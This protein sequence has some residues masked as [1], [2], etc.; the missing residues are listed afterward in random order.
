MNVRLGTRSSKL[1]L[2][3]TAFVADRLRAL[4]PGLDC[5]IVHISTHGDEDRDRPLP[6]IG[7]KGLFTEK[8]EEALREN[9][10]D[11]AVHS[12][13]DLPIDDSPGLAI[14]AVLG[15][16]EARDVVIS[17]DGRGLSALPAG[18]VVGTSSTRREAQL[19]ALRRDLNVKPIRGNVETRIAKVDR[20]E[21]E[22]TVIAGAGVMRL[23]L[24]DRVS[25]WIGIDRC[26]PAPGQGA[27]AVQCRADDQRIFGLLALIDDGLLHRVTDAERQFL[28]RLGG[29]CAAPVAAIATVKD[30]RHD[31]IVLHGRVISLDGQQV[32]EVRGEGDEPFALARRLADEALSAGAQRILAD[33]RTSAPMT[34]PLKGKRVLVTRPREQASDLLSLL[35]SRGAVPVSLPLIRIEPAGEPSR[36]EAALEALSSYDWVVFT[37][38][39]GVEHFFNHLSC[40]SLAQRTAAVGPAT[41]RALLARKITPAFIP[42][43]HT[44]AALARGLSERE[45]GTL[46]G[47]RILMPCA[48]A[49]TEEAARVLRG[50]GATVDELPFYRTVEEEPAAEDL[51]AIVNGSIDA[52][53]FLSGSAVRSFQA[54]AAATPALAE[55]L[56]R[57]VVGCIGSSTAESA[58]EA[59]IQ[60]DVVS[61]EHTMKALVQA[62]EERFR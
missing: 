8:I 10:I 4:V 46:A 41:A 19:R 32:I 18:A 23:G 59:G 12:L 11:A 55:T 58:R 29:G 24:A 40:R 51:A 39:N 21:Y 5:Q 57:A 43:E 22:A 60:V 16:E 38:A 31:R 37:S 3:Q 20:G 14:A 35:C 53:L 28:G 17:R 15:R 45:A 25:E 13:K 49:H 54:L 26:M 56:S 33:A 30:D 52:V 44:G 1:A 48:A 7:G 36:I 42:S 2:W 47:K 34:Q 50:A 6:E 61:S 62:L 27:L 9:K